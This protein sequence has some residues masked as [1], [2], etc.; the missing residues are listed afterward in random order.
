VNGITKLWIFVALII[1]AFYLLHFWI[2]LT[3]APSSLTIN[4]ISFPEKNESG[5]AIPITSLTN[6]D[7]IFK[8][9]TE[10]SYPDS[11]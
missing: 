1:A 7:L 6:N 10:Y 2:A 4:I 9:K 3:F 8:N 11:N 5:K